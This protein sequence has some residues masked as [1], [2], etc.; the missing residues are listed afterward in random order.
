MKYGSLLL[1][2]LGALSCMAASVDGKWTAQ[3]QGRNGTQTQ[4]LTL[5]SSGATLTGSLDTGRGATDIAEGKLDGMNVTFKVT[6]AGR[7]GNTTTDYAGKLDGDDLKLTAT[8]EGGGGGNGRGGGP[9]ELDFKRA[10]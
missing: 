1:C 5:K 8:R 10:K 4:T 6:R 7:N 9:Q 3:T 2:A